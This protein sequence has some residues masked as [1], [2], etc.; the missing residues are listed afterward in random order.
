MVKISQLPAEFDIVGVGG[1]PFPLTVNIAATD[2]DGGSID[3]SSPAVVVTGQNGDTFSFG[4]PTVESSDGQVVITWDVDATTALLEGG[5]V[6]NWAL[7]VTFSG[8]QSPIIAGTL[9]MVPATQGG[10]STSA[11]ALANV[12][13]GTV[14]ANVSVNIAGTSGGGDSGAVSSVFGR[15]GDVSAHTGDYNATEVGADSAGSAASAQ[16]A[17]EAYA[18]THK[19]DKASNLSD[20]ASASTARTNLGLGTAATHAST[21]FDAAGSAAAAQSAAIT[22]AETASDPA[23]TATSA[24]NAAQAAAETYADTSKLAKSANL[25]DIVSA[26]TARTNLG[27]GS[28]AAHPSTDFDASG[29]AA[30]A[31]STAE[32]YAD[33]NKLAIMS[34]LSDVASALTARTN[35]GVQKNRLLADH[36]Y[37]P[38]LSTVKTIASA[39]FAAIDT[40]NLTLSF[41][42]DTS[43]V[44]VELEALVVLLGGSTEESLFWA[45][46]THSTTTVVGYTTQVM[47][48]NTGNVNSRV[49]ARIR[50]TGLT[51]GNSYQVDWAWAASAAT[52][53]WLMSIQA[54]TTAG[55]GP[56]TMR[57]F[58]A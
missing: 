45:L 23:G 31:Q 4:A 10:A 34:N 30:T 2:S 17:A 24:A 48:S 9:Q 43:V 11:A 20:I 52:D 3:F 13:V 25:S 51:P 36:Y 37:E 57:A 28:A 38:S 44:M 53:T 50:L 39:T 16:T 14:T 29:A 7:L 1:F 55:A 35:L 41:T 46:F 22:A 49:T 58:S 15:Q 33:T 8:N 40:T 5:R 19:L 32:T 12:R 21:D 54:V 6:Y 47:S 26:A 18:D 56:A 42:A 27:L